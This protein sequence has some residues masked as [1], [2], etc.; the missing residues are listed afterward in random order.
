MFSTVK[1]AA[2]VA[3]EETQRQTQEAINVFKASRQALID[4]AT[5]EVNGLEF[6]ADE[7]SIGRMASAILATNGE[8]NSFVIQWSLANTDTGVMTEITV[9]EL[10]LAHK[11]SVQNM[12]NV[13][14]V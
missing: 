8:P 9:D 12:A 7:V 10:K 4:N 5:V 3:E 11:L 13:W 6:D 2:Q 14:G 1:K